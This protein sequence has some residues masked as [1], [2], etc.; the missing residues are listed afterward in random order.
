M[1]EPL[2]AK[3]IDP[4]EVRCG[5]VKVFLKGAAT[6]S[7][8]VNLVFAIFSVLAS[9]DFVFPKLDL[10]DIRSVFDNSI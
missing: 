10:I 4:V 1:L 7:T 2:V 8:W 6:H 5:E 3:I 9:M